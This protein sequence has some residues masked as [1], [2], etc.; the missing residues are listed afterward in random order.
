DVVTLPAVKTPEEF[1]AWVPSAKGKFILM[2]APNPSCRSAAQ[3]NEFGQVGAFDSLSAQR[4]VLSQEWAARM[5]AAGNQFEWTKAAGV[6]GVVATDWSQYPG[7]NKVFGS[8]RQ[9]VPTLEASCE[10]YNLL[11]RLAQNNQGQKVKV[12]AEAEFLGEQP[13][14]IVI[15]RIPGTEKP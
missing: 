12:N 10:E 6:A 13:V 3:W 5:L 2:S 11:F 7:V 14:F 4:R 9:Q 8:W 15:A 1:A